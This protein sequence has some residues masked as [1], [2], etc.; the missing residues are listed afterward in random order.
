L[1]RTE[2]PAGVGRADEVRNIAAA[3]ASF[4]YR[5][6]GCAVTVHPYGRVV[7]ADTL[8]DDIDLPTHRESSQK[9]GRESG[10]TG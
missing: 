10:R 8:S 5:Q 7:V 9:S 6:E 2:N 4:T 1:E 3:L